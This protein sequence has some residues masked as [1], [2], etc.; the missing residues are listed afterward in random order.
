MNLSKA[1]FSV[2]AQW[3]MFY[4]RRGG[5]GGGGIEGNWRQ[6]GGGR[7][8][9]R[10]ERVCDHDQNNDHRICFPVSPFSSLSTSLFSPFSVS[11]FFLSKN[12]FNYRVLYVSEKVIEWLFLEIKTFSLRN[13]D[14]ISILVLAKR[15]WNEKEEGDVVFNHPQS[16]LAFPT[17]S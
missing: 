17:P 10:E 8:S 11:S 9:G 6:T 13:I 7:G 2:K 4:D 16:F 14:K 5:K 12:T 1:N 15:K 3:K